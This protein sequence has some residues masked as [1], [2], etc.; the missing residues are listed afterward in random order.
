MT[1]ERRKFL[2]TAALAGAGAGIAAPAIA[3]SSP[4]IQWR[5][6]SSFPKSL[7]TIY[8]AVD[9]F[10]KAVSDMTDGNFKIQTF[11]AGEIVPGPGVLE[12]TQNGTVEVGETALYYFWGKDPTFALGT[13]IPF[14]L[15]P[16]QQNAWFYNGDGNKLM[17]EFLKGYNLKGLPGGNTGTQMGG[18]FRK[19]IKTVADLKGLKFRIGGMGGAVLSKLGVV[20]QSIPG[21]DIYP[22]LE[23]GTIDAAE[24]V[25]PYDDLKL[26][27]NKVAPYYYYPGFWEGGANLHYIFNLEKYNQLP[28]NYQAI[29][30]AATSVSNIWM[31]SKYDADNP[32]ALKSLVANGTKLRPFSQEILEA[33]YKAAQEL[34][35]ELSA[36]NANFKKIY[37]NMHEFQNNEY[38]WWQV[39][40]FTYDNFMVRQRAKG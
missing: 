22:S 23:K 7:D 15:N 18:W 19:E 9:I 26:G 11:A 17:D 4:K 10:A 13:A 30:D 25:G 28:K 1:V 3:Q 34:Y 16:R 32:A 37:D 40:E 6:A 5:L 27:F 14:G 24:W 2:K 35:K 20:P 39:A 36:K 21:G 8:G 31:Q 12:A 29:L 33:S 38:L